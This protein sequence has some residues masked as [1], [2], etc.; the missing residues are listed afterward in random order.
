MKV[1]RKQLVVVGLV[2]GISLV[3]AGGPAAAQDESSPGGKDSGQSGKS[4]LDFIQAGGV[5]GYVIIA[6]SFAGGG[7][8]IDSILRVRADKLLPAG[9]KQQ[10]EELARKGKFTELMSLA[11]ASDSL[12]GRILVG[13]LPQG[14]LGIDAVREAMAESGTR[15]VTRLQQRVGYVGFIAAV[16]PMLGLLGT[17]T[18]MIGSFNVLGM[19]KGAARPDQLAVGI[20]EALVTTCMGLVVAVPLMF[21]YNFLRDRVTRIG[22]EASGHCDLLLRFMTAAIA[23]RGASRPS[24]PREPKRGQPDA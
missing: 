2:L 5:V 11:Q 13:A 12:L 8:V 10:S 4:M 3:L 7:L 6:L 23:A 14:Q 19:A 21:F 1:T 20:S 22:Q 18:G 15:E 16:A 17:V 24:T 9:V